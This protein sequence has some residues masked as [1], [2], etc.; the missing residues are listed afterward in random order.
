MSYSSE[1]FPRTF[2]RT[3]NILSLQ[4]DTTN[5]T[6]NGATGYLYLV[7]G[8]ILDGLVMA[9]VAKSWVSSECSSIKGSGS[10]ITRSRVLKRRGQES[11]GTE[12]SRAS[13][14]E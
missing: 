12:K 5:T 7:L 8:Y 11:S 3:P 9:R 6:V 2:K 4:T 1:K 10:S 13:E 14:L